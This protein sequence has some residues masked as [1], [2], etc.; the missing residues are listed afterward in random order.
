[1]LLHSIG[2]TGRVMR[3]NLEYSRSN[4]PDD[5]VAMDTT[6]YGNDPSQGQW[7]FYDEVVN[8]FPAI[9]EARLVRLVVV[10]WEEYKQVRWEF[11]GC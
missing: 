3:Y 11:H 7:F 6:F 2:T 10:E 5:L 4:N 8:V 9:L 1:M